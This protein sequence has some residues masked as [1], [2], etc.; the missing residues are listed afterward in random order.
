MLKYIMDLLTIYE[1]NV[2]FVKRKH[3]IS[4]LQNDSFVL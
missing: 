3:L 2:D 1:Q 4:S